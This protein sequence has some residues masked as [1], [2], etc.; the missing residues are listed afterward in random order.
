M[1]S[2][3]KDLVLDVDG[4]IVVDEEDG[5][6]AAGGAGA[7]LQF[8]HFGDDALVGAEANGIAEEAGDGTELAAI[9]AAAAA[10]NGDDVERLP[11]MAV[12][13]HD[14]FEESGDAVELVDIETIPGDLRVVLQVR[15]LFLTKCVDGFVNLF[16]LAAGGVVDDAG[17]GLVGLA[18]GDGVGV[19]GSAIAAEGF[20]GAFGDVGSATR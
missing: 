15:F 5:D 14:T 12:V 18:E 20:F 8:Q 6:F 7:L 10:F 17:P 1:M 16:E 9:G 2:R 3:S 19:A 4:E 13:A 11:C